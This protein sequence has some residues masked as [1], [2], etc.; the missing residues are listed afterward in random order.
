MQ[1]IKLLQ[2]LLILC[3]AFNLNGQ[4]LN[5]SKSQML[6]DFDETVLYINTFAVHKDLNA[7][8]LGIDYDKEFYNLRNQINEQTSICE[9]KN[10][11]E[12]ALQLVQDLHCSFMPFDYFNA[13]GQY[14]KKFNF[15]NSQNYDRIKFFE[16]NCK[17]RTINLRL[18]L[19]Y[20][21]GDYLVY[22]DFIYKNHSIKRGTKVT[23]YNDVQID[24]FIANNYDKVWPVLWDQIKEKPYNRSFYGVGKD[25]FS[26]TFN[27]G[28]SKK[29]D[30]NLKDSITL[31]KQPQREIFYNSQSKAQAF[32]FEDHNILYI[33]M[34]HMDVEQGKSIIAK[35]DSIYSQNGA[36]NKII[37]DIRGNPGGN[38]MCW[39]NVLSHLI[40]DDISFHI[41][42]R[43]KYEP[44]VIDYY[45]KGKKNTKFEKVPL[46]NNT[47]YWIESNKKF[48]LKSDEKSIKHSGNIYVLQDKYIFSS[49]GNFSNFCLNS[50][51]LISVGTTTN[52]V[53]GLQTEPLFFK[54][55][56]SELIFRI[57]PMLDFSNVN[58]IQEFSHNNV[59]V[60]IPTTIDD[61]YLRTTYKGNL[62]SNSFLSQHDKLVKHVLEIE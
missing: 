9:F 46:L 51:K 35:V 45:N 13:Y 16:E 57:E 55:N 10:I 30:F 26:L 36:F 52:L 62:Y 27:N 19:L 43:Y 50:D 11:V 17:G 29:I 12:K 60:N 3:V 49:A 28:Q 56:N 47:K 18:P 24:S 41:D 7:V 21:N 34:P 42:L 20:E 22:T 1:K 15:G 53:G 32:Y 31:V 2:V 54:L 61:Y 14:Q 23:F 59:E 6:E 8:R 58:S 37:I 40:I 38:D 44:S 4:D 33:G 5:F 48:T 25:E 39:R